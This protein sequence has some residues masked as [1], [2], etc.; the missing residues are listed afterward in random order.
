MHLGNQKA[1]DLSI[2]QAAR[3]LFNSMTW[4]VKKASL[5]YNC[6][7]KNTSELYIWDGQIFVSIQFGGHKELN[8]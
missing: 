8:Y 4:A 1:S 7:A 6:A 2:L 5:L 3:K